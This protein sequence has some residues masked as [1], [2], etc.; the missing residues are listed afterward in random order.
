MILKILRHSEMICVAMAEQD[1][2]NFCGIEPHFLQAGDNDRFDAVRVSRVEQEDAI[3]RRDCIHGRLGVPDGINVI[4]QFDRFEFG[5]I[6]I[7]GSSI[8]RNAE[9]VVRLSQECIIAGEFL[10]RIDMSRDCALSGLGAGPAARSLRPCPN[11]VCDIN[12]HAARKT[13]SLFAI[14]SLTLQPR[15]TEDKSSG[16]LIFLIR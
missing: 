7:V 9:E 1:E 8:G 12:Q 16:E 11:P 4:E 14:G 10:R 6:R 13:L 5:R 3:R 15:L 2:F